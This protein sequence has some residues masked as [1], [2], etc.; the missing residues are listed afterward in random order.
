MDI[1]RQIHLTTGQF[2]KL[3]NVRKDTLLYYDKVGIFSP[4]IIASNG[5]RYYSVYQSDVFHVISILKELDM[6]LKEIKEFLEYRSPERLIHLLE[7]KEKALTTKIKH[8]ERMKKVVTDKL[9]VTKE[10]ME[11]NTLDIV[12]ENKKEDEFIVVTDSKQLTNDKNAYESIQLHYK[13]LEESNIVSSTSEGWMISVS[14]VLNGNNIQY[15]YLYTKVNES[16]YA[17]QKIEKGT[18]LVAYHDEG[19]LSI[20]QAYKRLVTYAKNHNLVLKGY[21]YED[22]LL[23]ELSVKGYEKYL[24]KLSVKI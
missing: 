24:I 19:Y 9:Y 6:P 10:A 14:N 11:V 16:S 20:E 3:M 22:A 17:N 5:Y 2:A 8:L 12:M 1:N 4:E 21:F 18:Y 15:D 13:Y 23:D 7:K